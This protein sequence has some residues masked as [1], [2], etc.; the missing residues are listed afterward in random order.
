M[1]PVDYLPEYLANETYIFIAAEK[2][3]RLMS[4]MC[5]NFKL[6]PQRGGGTRIT[7]GLVLLA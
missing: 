5:C 3:K 4:V 6:Q 7:T 2:L 1:R